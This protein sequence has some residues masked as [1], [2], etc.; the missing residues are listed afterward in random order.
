MF[1]RRSNNPKNGFLVHERHEISLKNKLLQQIGAAP[2]WWH[3]DFTSLLFLFVFFVHSVDNCFF[4]DTTGGIESLV[5][6]LMG[7]LTVDGI[8]KYREQIFFSF[9][10]VEHENLREQRLMQ[11]AGR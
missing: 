10:F 9:F 6:R 8:K 4:W 7:D 1:S 2:K 5:A 11:P 3:H